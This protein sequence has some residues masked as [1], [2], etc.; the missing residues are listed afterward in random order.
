[1]THKGRFVIS[2][3]YEFLLG[4]A[5][6]ELEQKDK[7]RM[8]DEVGIIKRLIVLFEKYKIPA[9]WAVTG[10]LLEDE[11]VWKNGLVHPEYPRP[12]NTGEKHDWFLYHPSKGEYEDPLWFDSKHLIP[13]IQNSL[14]SHEIA[15]HSYAHI[16]YGAK[17]VDEGAVRADIK[18][19]VRVH[20]KRGISISSFVFPRDN[21]K[22]HHLL[23]EIG[24]TCYRGV[25]KKWYGK[26]PRL[27]SRGLR[28][29]DYYLPTVRTFKPAMGEGG[30]VNIPE[31]MMLFSRN[32]VRKLVTARCMKMKAKRGLRVAI[33]KKEV[34]HLWF[35]PS[36]F[37]YDKETQF[38]IFEEIL[39]EATSLRDSGDL[40]IVTMRDLVEER[41]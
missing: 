41:Q 14:V 23:K 11:C 34:F 32:G 10:H 1:M 37:W 7:R 28:I 27:I 16:I 17:D 9:T 15:S 12:V 20:K 4:F 36:N 22:Y 30:L 29:I 5:D 8:E 39:K 3:D 2:I 13:A 40:E 25:A 35:H 33:Q 6:F 31:S 21:E 24:V 18:N 19:L 26:F 38:S